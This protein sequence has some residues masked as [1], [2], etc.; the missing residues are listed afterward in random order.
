MFASLTAKMP[1][2]QQLVPRR[3]VCFDKH[4]LVDPVKVAAFS[5]AVAL[6]PVPQWDQNADKHLAS[7]TDSIHD[8][9]S[10]YFPKPNAVFKLPY[11]APHTKALIV[12]RRDARNALSSVGY[13]RKSRLLQ[14]VLWLWR[15][16]ALGATW[17]GQDR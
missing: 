16:A 1:D 17:G 7:V 11:L 10:Y 5:N 14:G 9:L 6:I 3:Q 8:L 15:L 13:Q 4:A 2:E 12:S